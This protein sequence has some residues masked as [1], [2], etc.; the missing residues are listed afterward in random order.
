M[1]GGRGPGAGTAVSGA[2]ASLLRAVLR[3]T[4]DGHGTARFPRP[5]AAICAAF[6]LQGRRPPAPL[7]GGQCGCPVM[8][9]AAPGCPSGRIQPAEINPK[10]PACQCDIPARSI[11][12]PRWRWPVRGHRP[13]LLQHG[14]RS[15]AAGPGAGKPATESP[16]RWQCRTG[17]RTVAARRSQGIT[18][19][20]RAPLFHRCR[21]SLLQDPSAARRAPFHGTGDRVRAIARGHG[22][23]SAK[24][25]RNLQP[26]GTFQTAA[27]HVRR[28]R[29]GIGWHCGP[30]PSRARPSRPARPENRRQRGARP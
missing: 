13:R 19:L 22:A 1:S 29:R 27:G 28:C 6:G 18:A 21:R 11:R 9:R 16:M 10:R 26:S 8:T 23:V 24:A 15:C 20:P 2:A 17:G 25:E 30:G 7:R 3:L 4:A 12:S 14:D 5:A